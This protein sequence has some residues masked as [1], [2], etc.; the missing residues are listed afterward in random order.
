MILIL[1]CSIQVLANPLSSPALKIE[2]G[3]TEESLTPYLLLLEDPSRKLTIEDIKQGNY[4][5]AFTSPGKNGSNLSFTQSAWWIKIDIANDSPREREI[6]LRQAYPLIDYLDLWENTS[7]NWRHHQT[8]DRLPFAQ[9]NIQYHDFL[10]PLTLAPMSKSTLYLRYE[11]EGAMDIALSASTPVELIQN[12]S[13]EQFAYGVYYGGFLVLVV[14]NFFIF[15]VVR[16]KAFL[17]YLLY[18]LCF[19]LY[20]SA[21]DGFFYQMLMP[22][23]PDSANFSLLILL[24]LSLLFATQFSRHILTISQFSRKLDIAA[25]SVIAL[26]GLVTFSSIFLPYAWVVVTQATLTLV[27]MPL[28]FIMGVARLCSG[29]P[30]ARYFMLAWSTFIFGIM[31][32]MVKVFGYLP[33]TFFTENIFQIGSLIEMVLLSLALSSRVNELKK[34]SHTDALTEI[35]NRRMF[36]EV[37]RQEFTRTQR[38]GQPFSLL[39]IDIDHFKQFN[40]LYGHSQGDRVLKNVAAQL[41]NLI[42]KPMMPFR[43]GGEEFAVILPRTNEK[44]A[45]IIA[46][47]LRQH[48]CSKLIGRHQITVSIG[49]A[50]QENQVFQSMHELLNAADEALYAAKDNGRNC[51]MTF[52]ALPDKSTP[53]DCI[54][55]VN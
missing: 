50:C 18:I 8:G 37:M 42:R 4:T 9:R 48:I 3:F 45:R 23:S 41:R 30:P 47:R 13:S 36:D 33:R 32:Y 44:D 40:D 10:F 54:A 11:S 39:M 19:G 17:Y 34:Q 27:V 26:L 5:G 46:E 49:L 52:S 15:V 29:Y 24:G 14:Y 7:K 2:D 28:I 21:N 31:V 1:L 51:V 22:E 25:L 16:D 20:M 55:S 12:I 6:I 38:N 43:F 53:A 35:P